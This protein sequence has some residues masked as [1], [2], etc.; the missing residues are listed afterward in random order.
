MLLQKKS[1]SLTSAAFLGLFLRQRPYLQG[2]QP[3]VVAVICPVGRSVSARP[4]RLVSLVEGQRRSCCGGGQ[5]GLPHGGALTLLQDQRVR[6][7][8]EARG[9]AGGTT[10]REHGNVYTGV[11]KVFTVQL[12]VL[13]L[14]VT[15]PVR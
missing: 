10:E 8:L 7:G 3:D 2:I 6:R 13:L 15:L 4:G 12:Y 11:I 5:D 1:Y 14:C 9:D